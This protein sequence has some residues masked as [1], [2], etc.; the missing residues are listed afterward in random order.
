[1]VCDDKY[2]RRLGSFGDFDPK[3]LNAQQVKVEPL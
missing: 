1:M 2:V 3:G